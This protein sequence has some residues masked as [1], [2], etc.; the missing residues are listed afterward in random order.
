MRK[1][2][3]AETRPTDAMTLSDW[4]ARAG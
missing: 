4:I 2:M 1:S 3:A